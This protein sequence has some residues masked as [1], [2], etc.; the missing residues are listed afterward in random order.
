MVLHSCVFAGLMC[1]GLLVRGV[2]RRGFDGLLS[3]CGIVASACDVREVPSVSSSEGGVL[4]SVV[5]IVRELHSG[6]VV[7]GCR[8]I[9]DLSVDVDAAAVHRFVGGLTALLYCIFRIVSHLTLMQ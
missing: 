8:C 9:P 4:R 3:L 1:S 6:D 2:N 5:S 7:S